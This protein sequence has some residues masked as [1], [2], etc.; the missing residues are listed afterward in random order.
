MAALLVSLAVMSVIMS[1][2]LPVW[3]FQARREKEAELVFRG[4]QYAR[5][6]ALFARK[7][8]GAL[9]PNIDVLVQGRYLRKKYKDPMTEDGEFQPLFAGQNVPGQVQPAGPGVPQADAPVPP[10][11]REGRRIGGT[12][13]SGGLGV[14]LPRSSNTGVTGGGFTGGGVTGGGVRGG[15]VAGGGVI[16][17]SFQ[18]NP[19]VIGGPGGM[20][21]VASK[22]KETSIMLYKGGTRY[23]EWVFRYAGLQNQPGMVPGAQQMPGMPGMP[24]MGP[25][26]RGRGG[27]VGQPNPGGFGPGRFGPGRSGFPPPGGGRGRGQ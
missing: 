14:G 18:T 4:E 12:M 19:G 5:A 15:G 26:Q 3:R 16:G 6:I 2:V 27:R 20:M 23:N 1:A 8:A 11:S 7:N 24:G 25:G 13:T 22:S 21:G 10:G 9:P 17:G